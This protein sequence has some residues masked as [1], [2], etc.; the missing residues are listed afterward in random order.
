MEKKQTEGD[1]AYCQE[2]QDGSQERR[3]LVE[4]R[5]IAYGRQPDFDL[6]NGIDGIDMLLDKESFPKERIA[7]KDRIA[8]PMYI[9]NTLHEGAVG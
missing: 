5:D 7:D 3:D 2:E 1:A 4:T 9:A 8:L 6:A